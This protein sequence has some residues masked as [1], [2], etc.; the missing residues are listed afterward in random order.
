VN[1][2]VLSQGNLYGR[3]LQGPWSTT[4]A[5][6]RTQYLVLGVFFIVFVEVH[7]WFTELSDNTLDGVSMALAH[8]VT[9]HFLIANSY[10]N[11]PKQ[12]QHPI[13]CT[14]YSNCQTGVSPCLHL[15]HHPNQKPLMYWNDSISRNSNLEKPH[16]PNLTFWKARPHWLF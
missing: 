16:R 15:L 14:H 6:T 12:M 1:L 9:S 11:S 2:R 10:W 13:L 5:D 4:A 3:Y 7:S 8:T